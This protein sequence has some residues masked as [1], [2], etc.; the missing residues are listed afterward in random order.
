[1]T[2]VVFAQSKTTASLR[3][4]V[5]DLSPARISNTR[6]VL[7]NNATNARFETVTGVDSAYLLPFIVPGLYRVEATKDGFAA[8]KRDGLELTV[9]LEATLDVQLSVASAELAIA[10]TAEI[11]IIESQRTQ[12]SDTLTQ[13]SVRNLPINRRDY[14]TFSLLAPLPQRRATPRIPFHAAGRAGNVPA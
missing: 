6:I 8:W 10:V 7:T 14:L 13:D 1:L 3:G 4:N 9:G 2:G 11:P 12:Q 5:D